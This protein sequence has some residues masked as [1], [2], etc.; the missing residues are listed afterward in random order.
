MY[1]LIYYFLDQ[2]SSYHLTS[3][4]GQS[5]QCNSPCRL[6]NVSANESSQNK[7]QSESCIVTVKTSGQTPISKDV[8]HLS[9]QSQTQKPVQISGT[10]HQSRERLP[11]YENIDNFENAIPLNELILCN[12]GCQSEFSS[13]DGLHIISKKSQQEESYDLGGL[14][15]PSDQQM[16]SEQVSSVNQI[17]AK[18][19]MVKTKPQVPERTVSLGMEDGSKTLGTGRPCRDAS[20]QHGGVLKVI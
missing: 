11:F 6:S 7:G 9:H 1:T 19:I 15:H 12:R 5:S 18:P 10:L 20:T 4:S 13:M 3:E 16:G 14:H 17:G 2:C 8:S